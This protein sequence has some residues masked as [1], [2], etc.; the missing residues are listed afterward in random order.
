MKHQFIGFPKLMRLLL[1]RVF[2][3]DR[4]RAYLR[5]LLCYERY[6]AHLFRNHGRSVGCKILKQCFGVA[7]RVAFGYRDGFVPY[8]VWQST[9]HLGLPRRLYR[10]S[11]LLESTTS[12]RVFALSV[13]ALF[14]MFRVRPVFK[15]STITDPFSGTGLTPAFKHYIQNEF[16]PWIRRIMAREHLK[17]R[18]PKDLVLL[19]GGPWG[20]PNVLGSMGDAHVLVSG[21]LGDCP[22]A[23][24]VI[25]LVDHISGRP[26]EFYTRLVALVTRSDAPERVYRYASLSVSPDRGGK[27]RT[28]VAMSYWIQYAL[29]PIHD[30]CMSI[31][32]TIPEDFTYR[33]ND[34]GS[35][36][37]RVQRSG[38]K[39]YSYDLTDAT[40]RFSR[41]AQRVALGAILSSKIANWWNTIMHLP[42]MVRRRGCPDHLA[43]FVRYNSGQPM[44]SYSSW[45][46]FALTHH[47]VV[48]YAFFRVH[49]DPS[50]LYGVL[51][52]DVTIAYE[53]AARFY[54][55]FVTTHLGCAISE[56]KSYIP[57]ESVCPGEFAK[58]LFSWGREITPLTPDLLDSI[59]QHCWVLLPNVLSHAVTR[60]YFKLGPAYTD[61]PRLTGG[62][63]PSREAF[64]FC[65]F[66][67]NRP[68]CSHKVF[69]S[70]LERIN[71]KQSPI[72]QS[73]RRTLRI[74]VSAT[75]SQFG[76][77]ALS[78]NFSAPFF[79]WH[80]LVRL[81]SSSD[82]VISNNPYLPGFMASDLAAVDKCESNRE[83]YDF[84]AAKGL[85]HPL[86]R[87]AVRIYWKRTRW[88]SKNVSYS[89]QDLLDLSTSAYVLDAILL[90]GYR[91][92]MVNPILRQR[93]MAKNVR[94][95]LRDAP[96][97]TSPA[98]NLDIS[99]VVTNRS[100]P[101]LRLG[102]TRTPW[103]PSVPTGGKGPI[104]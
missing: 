17:L 91:P 19:R 4:S 47:C 72:H 61:L 78:D 24:A 52:D 9:D 74:R 28:F 20:I 58:R 22:V 100:P 81:A 18:L 99:E 37:L 56:A 8:L 79:V 60:W 10:V 98:V 40:D 54:R 80:S 73:L 34:V 32:R 29:Y 84:L 50:G 95:Y 85:H 6:V 75:R 26:G 16:R 97:P 76:E 82:K 36:I 48:R 41:N 102:V 59:N 45:P 14:L 33:Q 38:R 92:W 39:V 51:G 23:R 68:P 13:F 43:Q 25:S 53:P 104:K 2:R 86:A 101:L 90:R 57:T 7:K 1:V 64:R 5:A 71:G 103:R 88:I 93:M 63:R 11:C 30:L 15:L 94:N 67:V 42:I 44:G 3:R 12:H 77:F 96:F 83:V 89:H 62:L 46:V 66:P 21:Y 87:L 49:K 31:L 35:W 27:T 55:E 70:L 69:M 65:L